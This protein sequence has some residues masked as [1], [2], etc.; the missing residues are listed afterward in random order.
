MWLPSSPATRLPMC[1]RPVRVQPTALASLCFSLG[2]CPW[3]PWLK[4]APS[5]SVSVSVHIRIL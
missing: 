5:I 4:R 3:Q 1:M 2:W